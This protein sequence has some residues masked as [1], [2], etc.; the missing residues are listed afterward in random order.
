MDFLNISDESETGFQNIANK[1]FGEYAI[2]TNDTLFRL[3]DLEFY[4]RSNT[5]PDFSTYERK[6]VNPEQGD[7]FV[8]YSGVDIAL[9]M[10]CPN[11]ALVE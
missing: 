6:Y 9:K 7:W 3:I 8:H 1:L 10:R 11:L 4:W 5:H 2:K